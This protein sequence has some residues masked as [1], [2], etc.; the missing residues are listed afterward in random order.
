MRDAAIG[1]IE[2][3][4]RPRRKDLDAG[5]RGGAPRRARRGQRSLGQEAAVPVFVTVMVDAGS[6]MH[7]RA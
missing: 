3:I 4:P 1:T 5:E 7:R 2:S 6:G